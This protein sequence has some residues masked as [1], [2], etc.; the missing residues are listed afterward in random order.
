MRDLFMLAVL[1]VMLY[2]MVQRPFI[3]VGMWLWTALFYPNA[4]VYGIAGIPRYNLLFTGVAILSYLAWRT[5]PKIELTGVGAL[6]LAFFVWTLA[7]TT[8]SIGNQ[9]VSWDYWIRFSKVV[10]LFIAIVLVIKDKLHFDFVLWC[11]VLSVG[12]YADLETLKFIASG[13]GHK[14][15]GL[16][17]HVLGDRNELALAFV[18]TLP[19]CYYLWTEYGKRSRI[20]NLGLLGTMALLA[21]GVIGTESRGGFVALLMLGAYLYIKSDRKILLT[22]LIAAFCIGASFYISSDYVARMDTI[23]AAEQDDSFM[24]RVVA[25][26]L[27]F[28]MAMQHPF[29]GGGIKA[30]EY[31]PV[32]SELSKEFFAYPWFYTGTGFPNTTIARAA[33]SIY[34]QVLGDQG[35]VGLALYLGCLATSFLKAGGVARKARKRGAPA[36]LPTAAV[37]VQLS[38]FAFAVGGAALSLAYF[39]LIFALFG[40]V[41]V[42]E[43]RML[44]TVVPVPP[45][46]SETRIAAKPAYAARG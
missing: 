43:R 31:F 27:S 12:F 6:V 26:K 11:V 13:G 18:M 20:L 45:T 9:D 21:L 23:T 46:A 17:G 22:I 38:I 39:D 29:F 35:F 44:A 15:V 33:H 1:P 5:K 42:L 30:L 2:A 24:T 41:V 19:L 7:S 40:L 28:I 14:I 25:W 36:W 3:A 8:M 16:S 34:F 4:W 10:A 37:M 32:W